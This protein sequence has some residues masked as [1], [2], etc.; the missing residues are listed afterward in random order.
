MPECGNTNFFFFVS[1]SSLFIFLEDNEGETQF[2]SFHLLIGLFGGE[3]EGNRTSYEQ[4]RCSPH[5]NFFFFWLKA[6]EMVGLHLLFLICF[7]SHFV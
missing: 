5:L 1:T 3:S 4:H 2:P 7:T 6:A